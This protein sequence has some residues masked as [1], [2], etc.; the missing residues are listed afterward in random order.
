MD[1]RRFLFFAPAQQKELSACWDSIVLRQTGN[2]LGEV[3]VLLEPLSV[4]GEP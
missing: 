2:A 1:L 3:D 4:Q